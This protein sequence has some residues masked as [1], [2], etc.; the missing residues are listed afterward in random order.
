M[1]D[2]VR[3]FALK[4]ERPLSADAILNLK[5][6]WEDTTKGTGIEGS[7]LAVLAP[8]TDIV[9]LCGPGIEKLH[10]TADGSMERIDEL[11]E[12]STEELR[13]QRDR[14][15]EILYDRER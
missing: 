3:L 10:V 9:A 6:S 5:K 14:I 13:Q 1:S 4:T 8:G 15:N 2:K 12:L 11:T 7:R